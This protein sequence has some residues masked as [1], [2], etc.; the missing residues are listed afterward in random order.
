ME[1]EEPHIFSTTTFVVSAVDELKMSIFDIK[2]PFLTLT[3]N[4]TLT[5]TLNSTQILDLL[6]YRLVVLLAFCGFPNI[7][8]I[9]KNTELKTILV[10]L[11]L[12]RNYVILFIERTV[13]INIVESTINV[14]RMKVSMKNEE[15]HRFVEVARIIHYCTL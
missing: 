9:V 5:L 12:L 15:I 11:D 8:R 4:L 10:L 13:S 14:Y 6:R 7:L 3:L 1:F 2:V